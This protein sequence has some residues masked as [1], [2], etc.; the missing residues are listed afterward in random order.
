M[1]D[2]LHALSQVPLRLEKL[3]AVTAS[4]RWSS[5]G[6]LRSFE[7]SFMTCPVAPQWLHRVTTFAVRSSSRSDSTSKSFGI[8]SSVLSPS[9]LSSSS[10]WWMQVVTLAS[11]SPRGPLQLGS[12]AQWPNSLQTLQREVFFRSSTVRMVFLP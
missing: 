9:S 12:P 11:R 4:T 8:S 2:L 10:S 7:Q 1:T 3:S 5:P 6:S